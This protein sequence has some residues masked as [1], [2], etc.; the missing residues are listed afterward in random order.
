MARTRLDS[1]E[2]LGADSMLSPRRER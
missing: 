2:K 1:E